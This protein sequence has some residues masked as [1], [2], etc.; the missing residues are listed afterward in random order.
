MPRIIGLVDLMVVLLA[1][2][3]ALHMCLWAWKEYK[4]G[5]KEKGDKK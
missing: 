4:K 3:I 1:L 2:F 5:T